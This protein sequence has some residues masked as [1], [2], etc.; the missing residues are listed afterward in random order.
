MI[1]YVFQLKTLNSSTA[2]WQQASLENH[3]SDPKNVKFFLTVLNFFLQISLF[4]LI[5]YRK[6][7]HNQLILIPAASALQC[8]FGLLIEFLFLSIFAWNNRFLMFLSMLVEC[9]TDLLISTAILVIPAMKKLQT[10]DR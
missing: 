9:S 7:R 8:I 4:F 1:F 10:Y 6:K 5:F 2:T 3:I